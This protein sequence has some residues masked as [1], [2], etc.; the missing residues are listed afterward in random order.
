[1]PAEL[2]HL[3]VATVLARFPRDAETIWRLLRESSEFGELCEHL[4][5]ARETLCAFEQ[6]PGT[7]RRPEIDEYR[8]L[9]ADLETDVARL[10]A[11]ARDRDGTG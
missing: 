2:P 6:R 8:A 11:E 3:A 5:L 10:I 9:V 7:R 4:A 1:M